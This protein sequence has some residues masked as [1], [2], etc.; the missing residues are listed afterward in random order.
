M[1]KDYSAMHGI[2]RRYHNI[3]LGGRKG[4]GKDSLGMYLHLVYGY[5]LISFA[6]PL[7]QKAAEVLVRE[8]GLT[9]D[10]AIRRLN[11]PREKEQYRVLMQNI[12]MDERDED[13]LYWIKKSG[14]LTAKGLNVATDARFENEVDAVTRKPG[15][16]IFVR[17]RWRETEQAEDPTLQHISEALGPESYTLTATVPRG[18]EPAINYYERFLSALCF[19]APDE[20]RQEEFALWLAEKIAAGNQ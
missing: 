1:E 11:H 15:I 8:A 12:G 16:S 4:H 14:I 3:A 18:I 2:L 9:L 5:N 20:A 6:T 10:E 7:K 13:P 19:P 17:A